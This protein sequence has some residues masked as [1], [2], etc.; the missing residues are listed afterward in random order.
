MAVSC[1]KWLSAIGYRLSARKEAFFSGYRLSAIGYR[2]E[3]KR[4][5]VAIG[6][7]LP[8]AILPTADCRLLTAILPTADC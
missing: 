4:S 7:R 3:K 6:Y 8:T 5:L 2:Q 1:Q